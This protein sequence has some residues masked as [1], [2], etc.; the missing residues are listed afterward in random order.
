MHVHMHAPFMQQISSPFGVRYLCFK[1]AHADAHSPAWSLPREG[2]MKHG[3]PASLH[4]QYLCL[5]KDKTY[6]DAHPMARQCLKK[7]HAMLT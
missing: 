1:K 2:F 6:A 4:V 5:Q 3:S 7:P